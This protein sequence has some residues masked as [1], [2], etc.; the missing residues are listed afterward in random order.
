[1]KSDGQLTPKE[2]E[3]LDKMLDENSKMINRQE[4]NRKNDI[5]KIY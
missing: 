3:K 2:L 1:M 5:R 4:H